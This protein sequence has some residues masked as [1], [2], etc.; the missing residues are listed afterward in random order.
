MTRISLVVVGIVLAL[1]VL[2]VVWVMILAV[3]AVVNLRDWW[4]GRRHGQH[5]HLAILKR[6]AAR[7]RVQQPAPTMGL[8]RRE[9]LFGANVNRG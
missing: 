8:G 5:R 2:A 7:Q 3:M 9:R 6:D 4:R 1:P